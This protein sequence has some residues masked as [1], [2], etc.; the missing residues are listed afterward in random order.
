M[1][2]LIHQVGGQMNPSNAASTS[3]LRVIAP[4]KHALALLPPR[5]TRK[6][7]IIKRVT[8]TQRVSGCCTHSGSRQTEVGTWF[9][10]GA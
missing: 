8:N 1:A 2:T 6:F 3:P 7:I 9:K 10:Y 5:E 4:G